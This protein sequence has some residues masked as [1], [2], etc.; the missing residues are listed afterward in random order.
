MKIKLN[1]KNQTLILYSAQ[2]VKLLVSILSFHN[3]F[4]T[5][6]VIK[7]YT[8]ECGKDKRVHYIYRISEVFDLQ[9][10]VTHQLH[11]FALITLY[12][13]LGT[14]T[15]H[16]IFDSNSYLGNR[17]IAGTFRKNAQLVK[18]LNSPPYGVFIRCEN[19]SVFST[20]LPEIKF[21]S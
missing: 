3:L 17:S 19:S 10:T 11:G 16:A 7:E 2:Y 20:P 15:V 1:G 21:L 14:R 12:L 13:Y 18:F 8:T 9:N 4:P 6:T 5:L